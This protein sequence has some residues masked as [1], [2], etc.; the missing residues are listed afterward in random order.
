MISARRSAGTPVRRAPA[1]HSA[2]S[3]CRGPS[4]LL[5][6]ARA[7]RSWEAPRSA[8]RESGTCTRPEHHAAHAPSTFFGSRRYAH[9]PRRR[10]GEAAASIAACINVA[11]GPVARSLDDRLRVRRACDVPGPPRAPRRGR[12]RT[13]PRRATLYPALGNGRPVVVPMS[14]PSREGSPRG[15]GCKDAR[16]PAMDTCP[17][18]EPPAADQARGHA[19]RSPPTTGLGASQWSVRGRHPTR[20]ERP[21]LARG[22]A[23]DA[24]VRSGHGPA[25]ALNRRGRGAAEALGEPRDRRVARNA[26]Q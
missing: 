13:P 8:T 14:T 20:C 10:R 24:T 2:R 16:L 6:A 7:A 21:I 25:A 18:R 9:A 19:A 5:R 22:P 15:R 26:A 3:G 4:Q 1:S 11:V 23:P 17:R 12:R